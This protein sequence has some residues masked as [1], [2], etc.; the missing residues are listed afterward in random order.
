MSQQNDPV[1]RLIALLGF[2]P[3]TQ[4]PDASVLQDALKEITEE[5]NEGLKE[6]A[7]KLLLEAIAIR[8]EK[9]TIENQFNAASKKSDKTLGKLL[10]RIEAMANGKPAP[11]EDESESSDDE[12]SSGE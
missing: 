12:S 9:K 8:R 5:R 4:R 2:D 10:N 11:V 3:A 6:E 7:K 1:S